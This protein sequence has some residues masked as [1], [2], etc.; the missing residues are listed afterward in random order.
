MPGKHS[1][2]GAVVSKCSDVH[3]GINLAGDKWE[4]GRGEMSLEWEGWGAERTHG[5]C[6]NSPLFCCP[7]CEN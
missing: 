2:R 5:I 7:A 6:T 1:S 4:M 3:I